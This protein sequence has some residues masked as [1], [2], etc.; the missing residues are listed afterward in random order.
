MDL[1]VKI[2]EST[3]HRQS[4]QTREGGFGMLL[5]F[6]LLAL[7][8][9]GVIRG[10]ATKLGCQTARLCR[11]RDG[12][13]RA[14]WSTC[15]I[16]GPAISSAARV[17][18]YEAPVCVLTQQA[19][20]ALAAVQRDL[21]SPRAGAEGVR[22]LPPGTRRAPFRALGARRRQQHQGRILSACRK[23]Q[24]VSRRLYRV[25]LRSFARL[26]RRSDAGEASGRRGTRHGHA[27]RFPVAAIGTARQGECGGARQSQDCWPMRCVRAASFPTTRNGGTSRCATSRFR[28]A[29]SIFRCAEALLA[30]GSAAVTDAHAQT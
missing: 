21:Q 16:S 23:G 2:E 27:V 10:R 28:T 13:S 15:A 7:T 5:R 3:E 30:S 20:T 22:L 14:S 11:C 17:D 6:A 4:G 26:D 25:A 8:D 19:A 12:R 24:P 9:V 1:I 29:I 18:G